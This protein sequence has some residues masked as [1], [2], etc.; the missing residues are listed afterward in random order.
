MPYMQ[1]PDYRPI[2]T[3]TGTSEKSPLIDSLVGVSE[4]FKNSLVERKVENFRGSLD[5]VLDE[6]SQV[7]GEDALEE[8]EIDFSK[9]ERV[10]D[11]GLGVDPTAQFFHDKMRKISKMRAKGNSSTQALADLQMKQVLAEAK[12]K[13]PRLYDELESE[14]VRTVRY[15]PRY[16]ALGLLDEMNK[17][18]SLSMDKQM[19]AYIDHGYKRVQDGGLGIPRTIP[20]DSLAFHDL[21]VQNQRMRAQEQSN[22]LWLQANLA[23]NERS[24]YEKYAVLHDTLVGEYS[25]FNEEWSEIMRDA[26]R[27]N[28]AARNI[29]S[30]K[31]SQEDLEIMG[32][33]DGGVRA[34][35]EAR[36]MSQIQQNESIKA[37]I[38]PNDRNTDAGKAMIQLLDDKTAELKASIESFKALGKTTLPEAAT[39]SAAL[40]KEDAFRMSP[41]LRKLSVVAPIVADLLPLMETMGASDAIVKQRIGVGFA[42]S[43]DR[44]VTDLA[45][46]QV[47]LKNGDVATGSNLDSGG[48]INLRGMAEAVAAGKSV[49]ER[50]D[51]PRPRNQD[52]RTAGVLMNLSGTYSGTILHPNVTPELAMYALQGTAPHILALSKD[53]NAYHEDTINTILP[54]IADKNFIDTAYKIRNDLATSEAQ[55]TLT[56]YGDILNDWAYKLPDRRDAMNKEWS[57]ILPFVSDINYYDVKSGNVP[58]ITI[59]RSAIEANLKRQGIPDTLLQRNTDQQARSMQQ[60]ADDFAK[61]WMRDVRFVAHLQYLRNPDAEEALYSMTAN[62][63]GYYSIL[64][65]K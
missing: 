41:D 63:I 27:A 36:L 50:P 30:N 4:I 9:E 19:Q 28:T 57:K 2:V 14:Y 45:L 23:N 46:S 11:N 32:Q 43:I 26:A 58:R 49:Y 22:T 42:H 3:E 53:P 1:P 62:D 6:A 33:W 37:R 13:N 44:I 8:V 65:T 20:S 51:Q 21:Y 7:A 18:Q 12:V 54:L 29:A 40:V 15:D 60:R 56:Q 48:T 61:Q 5:A 24:A 47:I 52:E 64:R 31:A 17:E 16:E 55:Q 10:Y 35:A 34:E 38:S 59:N 25:V 39:I